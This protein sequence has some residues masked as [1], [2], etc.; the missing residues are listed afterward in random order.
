MKKY[1]RTIKLDCQLTNE[2]FY[3]LIWVDILYHNAM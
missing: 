1:V 3:I 2:L